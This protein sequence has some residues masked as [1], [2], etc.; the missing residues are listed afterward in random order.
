MN[1]LILLA[2][3][4]ALFGAATGAQAAGDPAAGKTKSATCA[5]CHNADGNSTNPDYPS[6]AGQHESY[7]YKQLKDYKSGDRENA[8]MAGMVAPLSDQDMQDLAAYFATQELEPAEAAEPDLV[9]QGEAIYQGGDMSK[10]VPAC[11]ACH[12][13]AG[14]GNPGANFPRLAGQIPKYT[15][16]QLKLF[17]SMERNNDAGQM[18]RNIA[19]KMTD[20]EIKAVSSYIAGLRP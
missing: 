1:K 7:L 19:I 3:A 8:I 12:G 9:A 17:R 13:P 20:P 2:A 11:S 5:A 6:L 14:L 18:M 4:A 10:G 15:E 16:T